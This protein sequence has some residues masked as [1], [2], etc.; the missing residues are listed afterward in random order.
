MDK[1][2]STYDVDVIV[3]I[4]LQAENQND[5]CSNAQKLVDECLDGKT[6]NN[7]YPDWIAVR[8]SKYSC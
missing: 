5:A 3:T 8:K 6:N 2:K 1:G 7:F 4:T